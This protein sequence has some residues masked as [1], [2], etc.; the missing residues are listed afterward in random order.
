MNCSAHYYIGIRRL[1]VKVEL[2]KREI[3]MKLHVYIHVY[4]CM[5]TP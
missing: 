5:H 4:T 3:C 2:G 1:V